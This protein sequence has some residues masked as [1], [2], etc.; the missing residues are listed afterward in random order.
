MYGIFMLIEAI[1]QLR[2]DAG[3][4]QVPGVRTA[5]CNG[6]GGLLASQTTA[7]LGNAETL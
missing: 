5:L 3:D 2:G 7:I 6:N 1:E 4:R